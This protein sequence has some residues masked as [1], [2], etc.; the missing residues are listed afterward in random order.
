MSFE[1]FKSGIDKLLPELDLVLLYNWGEP[2]LNPELF[3]CIEY[4]SLQNLKTHLSSNLMMYNDETGRRLVET[5]LTKLIVSAD[6][7]RQE[8][9]EKYRRGGDLSK[10]SQAVENLLDLKMRKNSPLPEIEMQFVVFKHNEHE[11]MEYESHWKNKGV[12]SV[13]FI[14]MSF[15]SRDGRAIATSL[16]MVPGHPEFKPHDP[17]GTVRS[18]RDLYN[19]I[20]I[21]WN[22]DW[23]T[24][25]F[26]SGEKIYRVGNIITDDFWHIWNGEKYKYCRRLVRTQTSPSNYT[27]TMCHDCTGVYPRRE[28]K[29]YWK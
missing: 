26:P 21:D 27:E 5:G 22:G 29:K 2:L 3:R 6:G 8:T 19:H 7:L 1:T 16:D 18:C 17:Y 14:K 10:V 15:M 13:R 24:C 4:A 20:S 9:Y 12:D 28:T 23:Y 25:C 11:M